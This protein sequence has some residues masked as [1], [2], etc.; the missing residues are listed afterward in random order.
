[1]II[2]FSIRTL[3]KKKKNKQINKQKQTKDAQKGEHRTQER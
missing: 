2:K 1:M 3:K